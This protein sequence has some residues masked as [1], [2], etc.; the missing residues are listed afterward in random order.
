MTTRI[1]QTG[2]SDIHLSSEQPIDDMAAH[3][4]QD[5]AR[6]GRGFILDTAANAV[7]RLAPLRQRLLD[8]Q[9]AISASETDQPG[10]A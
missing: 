2:D 6:R 9:Q 8:A 5:I 10:A 4:M 7:Q 1:L 3:L